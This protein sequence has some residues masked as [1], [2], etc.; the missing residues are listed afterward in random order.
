VV[1]PS[2]FWYEKLSVCAQ[3]SPFVFFVAA[4]DKMTRFHTCSCTFIN[5]H[6]PG[7][8]QTLPFRLGANQKPIR[9]WSRISRRRIATTIELISTRVVN[10]CEQVLYR[11]ACRKIEQGKLWVEL[12]QR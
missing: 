10:L 7:G 8:P 4:I 6:L 5:F 1:L 2:K 11:V 9:A 3:K 12:L